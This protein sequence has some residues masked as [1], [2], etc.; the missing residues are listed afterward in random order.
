MKNNQIKKDK[1]RVVLANLIKAWRKDYKFV[2][3]KIVP[4]DKST[5]SK[6]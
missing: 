3:G 4:K 6:P 1:D 5:L 2:K